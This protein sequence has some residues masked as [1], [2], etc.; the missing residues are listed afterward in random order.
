M[1]NFHSVN[2]AVSSKNEL[3]VVICR[4]CS[5]VVCTLPT[6]GIKKISG[7][8]DKPECRKQSKNGEVK[9]G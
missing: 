7:V 6:N 1:L 9:V 5:D 8:C 2:Q 3:G 4:H